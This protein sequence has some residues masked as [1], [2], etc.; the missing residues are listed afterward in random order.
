M[1]AYK[2]GQGKWQVNF[3][4]NG[5]QRT[6]YLGGDFTSGSADRVARI[7][8][9]IL[10][11][12]NRGDSVPLEV[13]RR[14]ETLPERVQAS[15]EKHGLIDGATSRTLEM[16]LESFYESKAHLKANSQTSYKAIGNLLLRHFGGST[17]ISSI[18]KS[19][20]ERLKTVLRKD[21][22][23]CSVTN[24]IKRGRMI[25]K[26][27]V[28][29]E[30]LAKNPFAGISAGVDF[31]LDR[32]FYVDRKMIYRVIEHCRDDYDRLLLALARFAGLRIPS[33]VE[34][35]RFCDF[36]EN[37]IHIHRETKTGSREV[38]LFGEIR[39]IFTQINN[40]RP[41]V[42]NLG[43][44]CQPTDLVF[45]NLGNKEAI[46]RRILAAIRASGVEQWAKLFVNLRSSC[47][48]DMV[49]RGYKEKTLDA[50][51]GNSAVIRSR[52]YVQF[53]KEKEYAKVLADNAHMLK[54]LHEGVDESSI[55]SM[56]TDEL[57]VLRDL[58]VNR[59]GTGRIA[60]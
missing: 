30:W 29:A 32:M 34:R 60:S 13:L 22:S 6:L 40:R 27:A 12:R 4:V 59:F 39:E 45:A 15:F 17:K 3:S 26:L 49:E 5:K 58:L 2:T 19:A 8:T 14:I 23:V 48:T 36:T 31:N 9:D 25:F 44:L 38:P 52:H 51:F 43:T 46:R 7:V 18:E 28:D 57:L 42:G 37:V 53:R 20:C 24:V 41:T 56:Q 54:L 55:F 10:A 16:L 21:Y 33:E 47:I 35:L 11:C 1:Q 50:M